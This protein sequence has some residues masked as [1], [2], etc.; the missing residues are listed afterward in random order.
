MA[1]SSRVPPS[2]H[3]RD[4][5]ELLPDRRACVR[6]SD[7]HPRRGRRRSFQL[8][9]L[10]FCRTIRRARH[11]TED[12]HERLKRSA[13]M[14]CAVAVPCSASLIAR[15]GAVARRVPTRP[16]C[17]RRMG[18][19]RPLPDCPTRPCDRPNP[20]TRTP[21]RTSATPRCLSRG[22]CD[23]NVTAQSQ[24]HWAER[25]GRGGPTR[26]TARRTVAGPAHCADSTVR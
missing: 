19:T 9:G 25:W 4:L 6:S 10:A 17:I 11:P 20:P 16:G 3:P 12:P 26:A 15:P 1:R 18:L 23:Q 8:V 2:Y 5:R 24:P 21:G 13:F 14:P 7:A 22:R